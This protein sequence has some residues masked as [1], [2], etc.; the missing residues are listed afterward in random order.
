[1]SY[2]ALIVEQV[3]NAYE[4]LGCATATLSRTVL[5]PVDPGTGEPTSETTQTCP[6]RF[7][8]GSTSIKG[9]GYKFGEGLIKG[10]ELEIIIPAMNLAFAPEAGD[11]ITAK[12]VLYSVVKVAPSFAPGG[13][14]VEFSMLV[15]K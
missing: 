15:K 8:F 14:E 13:A 11:R 6:T 10:G 1:M 2:D 9:L 3:Y 12:G 7:K 5:G 4:L